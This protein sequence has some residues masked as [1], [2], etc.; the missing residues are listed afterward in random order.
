MAVS[1][2]PYDL[3]QTCFFWSLAFTSM[4][5][6]CPSSLPVS[7]YCL[8][9]TKDFQGVPSKSNLQTPLQSIREMTDLGSVLSGLTDSEDHMQ[10]H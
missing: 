10:Q 9:F 5:Q 4:S 3:P 6:S 7:T 1:G 2:L 8:L